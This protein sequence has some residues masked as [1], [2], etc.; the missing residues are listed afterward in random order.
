MSKKTKRNRKDSPP[1]DEAKNAGAKHLLEARGLV[2]EYGRG[3]EKLQVLRG[4]NLWVDK[5][6]IVLIVGS[7]GTGKSTLL[8]TLGLLDPPSKGAVYYNGRDL[9]ALSSREQAR[10]RNQL[11]GFV[12]QFFHLLPDFNALENVLMPAT[13]GGYPSSNGQANPDKKQARKRAS[14][15]LDRV[16]LSERL[17]HRPN[18]L[19]GGERQRVAIARAL[20]NEP[21]FLMMDEPTG[22]L[23]TTT[24]ERIHDLIWELNLELGQTIVIVTHDQE[25]A[26][27][28]ARILRMRDGLIV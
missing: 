26:R 9:Y 19:S 15:L 4:M 23:D 12:F 22:N 25:L 20:M 3:R 8:H 11:F 14:D 28:D 24:S 7:S 17:K 6:E 21:E 18:E 2:K 27:R 1:A 16:G 13:V 10:H 5:G